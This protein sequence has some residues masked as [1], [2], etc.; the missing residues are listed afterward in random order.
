MLMHF[1]MQFSMHFSMG[2]LN[3]FYARNATLIRVFSTLF[4]IECKKFQLAKV[5]R[6]KVLA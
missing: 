1:P 5:K 4:R 3:P 6:K 2:K